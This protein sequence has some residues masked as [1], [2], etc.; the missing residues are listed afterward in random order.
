MPS[1]HKL[2]RM[3]KGKLSETS[4]H[5][6]RSENLSNALL[7]WHAIERQPLRSSPSAAE[8]LQR[9]KLQAAMGSGK[10]EDESRK[11]QTEGG[12]NP[13]QAQSKLEGP[14]LQQQLR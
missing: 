12:G 11:G 7:N 13:P 9:E 3:D 6:P 1:L 2:G 14:K 8:R 10:R 5:P 4:A